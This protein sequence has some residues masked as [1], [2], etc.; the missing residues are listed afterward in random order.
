[1]ICPVCGNE[2]EDGY[3]VGRNY[4]PS[5]LFWRGEGENIPAFEKFIGIQG[6]EIQCKNKK[7]IQWSQKFEIEA[8][9]C[10]RCEKILFDGKVA[11]YL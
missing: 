1:M 9:Y 7:V 3:L 11:K 10:P 4:S 8:N 2:M 6:H 5:G